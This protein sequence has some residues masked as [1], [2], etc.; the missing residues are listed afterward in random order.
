MLTLRTGTPGAGKTLNT[1]KDIDEEYGVDPKNPDKKVRDIYYYN[2][3]ELDNDKLKANWIPFDN[4]EEW[5]TYPD[6]AM[7]VIDEAQEIFPNDG[8]KDRPLK[9]SKM[10]RHRHQGHDIVLITQHPTLISPHVRKLVGK[11]IHINRP[12][13]GYRL[14]KFIYEFCVDEPQRSA[15]FALAQR[16]KIKLDKKY[17]GVYKSAVEHTHKFKMPKQYLTLII[18]IIAVIILTTLG[19]RSLI[20]M[21]S[22]NNDDNQKAV[23]KAVSNDLNMPT[24]SEYSRVLGGD[25]GKSE[26]VKTV[27]QY[28]YENTPRVKDVPSSAPRYDEINKPVIMPKPNCYLSMD[29]DIV[30]K[31]AK[32]NEELGYSKPDKSSYVCRCYTQQATKMNISINACYNYV[33][34]G[35]F[36]DTI[37]NDLKASELHS[38]RSPSARGVISNPVRNLY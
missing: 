16:F 3:P 35:Y 5:Y 9:I 11:H 13:G 25:L 6:G 8:K 18:A 1:I 30:I 19:I 12:F 23:Q 34:N 38:E 17:F 33:M 4:P 36:D 37:G 21:T 14:S 22:D 27:E 20:S 29:E 26:T 32:E 10:E 31:A 28:I 24:K 15:N 7:F 2:I